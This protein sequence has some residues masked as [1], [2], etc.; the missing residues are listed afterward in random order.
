MSQVKSEKSVEYILQTRLNNKVV[1]AFE[2][3]QDCNIV[4]TN[5]FLKEYIDRHGDCYQFMLVDLSKDCEL[6]Q[7]VAELFETDPCMK[8]K[9]KKG[10][11]GFC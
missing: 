2:L 1:R 8:K 11:V 4:I 5:S 10:E 3:N 9:D 6:D 7:K